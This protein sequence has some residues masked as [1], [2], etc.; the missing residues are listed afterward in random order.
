MA[1]AERYMRDFE[2]LM[3]K[4]EE[5]EWERQRTALNREIEELRQ[6][7]LA[8]KQRLTLPDINRIID[9]GYGLAEVEQVIWHR[10]HPDD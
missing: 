6:R 4:V 1:D 2:A 9:S 7:G 3:A 5:R 8:V 10:E